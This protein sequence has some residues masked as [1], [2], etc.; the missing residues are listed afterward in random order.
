V[1]NLENLPCPVHKTLEVIG[2]RW[3]ALIVRD[4]VGGRM[5]F[6]ELQ[7]SLA[8]ITPK[9]L[10]QRLRELEDWG[11][12]K[13]E[14]YPDVPVRVEYSL[15]AMGQD[16]RPIIDS[17]AAWGRRWLTGESLSWELESGVLA[18]EKVT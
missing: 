18:G 10:C 16:L 15:T 6:T 12:I 1:K 14:V 17:M 4:L 8:G 3:T 11:I 2:K 5:R 13:R 9:M 7:R